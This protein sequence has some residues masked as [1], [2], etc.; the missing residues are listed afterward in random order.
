MSAPYWLC[1]LALPALAIS[2]KLGPI[3]ASLAAS[4]LSI[5][6]MGGVVA[7][8]PFINPRAIARNLPESNGAKG[9]ERGSL[10]ALQRVAILKASLADA[11]QAIES[12]STVLERSSSSS[13]SISSSS[14]SGGGSNSG[15]R[16]VSLPVIASQLDGCERALQGAQ[17][18]RDEKGYV[19]R[20][21]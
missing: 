5:A 19:H 1:L 2:L 12:S 9:E 4:S 14:S 7:P 6:V 3:R 10:R 20:V 17:I 21:G 16:R 18:P 8:P 13:I 15:V 11:L